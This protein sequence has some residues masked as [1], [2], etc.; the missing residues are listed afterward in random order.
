MDALKRE[1]DAQ[2]AVSLLGQALAIDSSHEDT[3][4]YL[5]NAL[6]ALGDI[7]GALRQ[8]D[9]LRRR[10]PQ[11]HRAHVRWGTLRAGSASSL[12]QLAAAEA[13]L[14]AAHRL[15]PEETGAL[16]ALGEVR[17]LGGDLSKADESLTAVSRS[18]PRSADALFLRGYIR[19]KQNDVAAAKVLLARCRETRGPEWKPAG[20]TAEGDVTRKAHTEHTP[21]ARFVDEWGGGGSV[22]AAYASLDRRL[23]EVRRRLRR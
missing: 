23:A 2:R 6:V 15:N 3:R 17:L 22:G 9:E 16:T 5:G 19:W 8:F 13:A 18:N 7:D 20:T 12:D 21:L 11:S 1:D 10:S 14:E 4:Y